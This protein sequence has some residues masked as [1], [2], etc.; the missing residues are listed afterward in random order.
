MASSGTNEDL[1][2][3]A[4]STI[5]PE[6]HRKPELVSANLFLLLQKLQYQTTYP[7]REKDFTFHSLK[8]P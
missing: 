4:F 6:P 2:V 3:F 1:Q 5:Q 7:T 8:D